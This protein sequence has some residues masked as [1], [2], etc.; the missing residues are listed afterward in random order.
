MRRYCLPLPATLL[1]SDLSS[2][3]GRSQQKAPAHWLR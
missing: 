1:L 2:L 3:C